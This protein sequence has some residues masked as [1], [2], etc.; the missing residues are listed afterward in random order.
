MD[1]KSI[2]PYA[3]LA[4]LVIFTILYKPEILVRSY[5]SNYLLATY[6]DPYF[7]SIV[8]TMFV[9]LLW[10]IIIR[11]FRREKLIP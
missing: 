11:K 9:S 1:F 10:F 6:T 7:L 2:I 5:T 3:G 8:F 4:L